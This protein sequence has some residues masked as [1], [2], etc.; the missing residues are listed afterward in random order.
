MIDYG[1]LVSMIIA[2]GVP[3]LLM[4]WWPL[5]LAP[6]P[7][8]SDGTPGFLDAAVG[9]A[10]A[11]LAVG[12]LTSLA[13]DDPNSIGSLSDM[14][15]IRSGV[16]FWP[17]VATAVVVVLWGEHRAGLPRLSRL[18][19]LVPLSMVGYAAYEAAC[20]FRDGCFGPDSDIGL[21]PPG[22][23]TT[24]FP[25]GWVMAAVLAAA[26][27][28]VRG[29]S[30]R[31]RSRVVVVAAATVAVAGVRAI[32]SIWLPRVGEGLTRQHFTSI[33]VAMTAGATLAVVLASSDGRRQQSIRSR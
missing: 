3:S 29:L 30:S 16:E 9:P 8:A 10:F 22:L 5:D 1:L 12:R 18:A 4:W 32:G 17:G 24:M 13:L 20:I 15:I 25:I 31:V 6:G 7:P 28:A 2:F 21:R 14:L 26:A 23:S 27:V 33:I 19:V 11:G